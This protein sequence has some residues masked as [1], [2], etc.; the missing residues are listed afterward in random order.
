MQMNSDT[1]EETIYGMR[2]DTFLV[3][4]EML[5]EEI[6]QPRRAMAEEE[7]ICQEII[8]VLNKRNRLPD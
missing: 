7:Q 3:D 1:I 4:S 5:S 2:Y 8:S 6:L